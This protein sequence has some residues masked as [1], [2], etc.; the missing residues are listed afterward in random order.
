MIQKLNKYVLMITIIPR[1]WSRKLEKRSKRTEGRMSLMERTI[2]ENRRHAQKQKPDPD[3]D[4]S[5][6]TLEL[7][8][9]EERLAALQA[10]RDELLIGLKGLQESMK[11]Q[12]LR[13]TR[14]EGRLEEVL[15]LN[16]GGKPRGL[17][18]VGEPLNSDITPQEYYEPRRRSQTHRR[19]KTVR[20]LEVHPQ[21]RQEGISYSQT[22]TAQTRIPQQP[23]QYQAAPNQP[24]HSLT[25]EQTPTDYLPQP[26]SYRP[27][28]QIQKPAQTRPYPVQEEAAPYPK[29]HIQ[30]Q[31]Q[32]LSQAQLYD[33][34]HHQLHNTSSSRPQPLYQAPTHPEPA[35]E[36]L[37][38]TRP[39]APQPRT[40]EALP[41]PQSESYQPSPVSTWAEG[42]KEDSNTEVESSV[43]HNLLQLPVRQKIPAQPVRK[44]HATSKY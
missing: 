34:R 11:S 10:Q 21:P 30:P 36:R 18:R 20:I 44:K 6:L 16:G 5:N 14:L 24:K 25:L 8:S 38:R 2:R 42:D 43:I 33:Q 17:W 3:Q 35:K 12:A 37:G 32:Q 23:H 4:F 41:R 28:S 9:Q 26:E 31:L 1:E 7:Q 13:V 19:G 15:Q 22:G 27:Q 40:S 39:E 29:A